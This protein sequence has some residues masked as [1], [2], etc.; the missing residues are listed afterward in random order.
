MNKKGIG[1]IIMTAIISGVSIYLNKSGVSFF[2]PVV[3]TFMKNVLAALILSLIVLSWK[4]ISAISRLNFRSWITLVIIGLI[5]GSLP[6]ILFFKG[7]AATSALQGSFIHKTMFIYVSAL[8]VIF[9]KEKINK[10]FFGGAI[11]VLIGNLIVIRGLSLAPNWG[12][13][14]ILSA[15]LLWALENIISKHA[16]KKIHCDTIAWARMFFGAIF[17]LAYL[18]IN[19]QSDLA[20]SLNLKQIG[21]VMLASVLLSGYVITWYR[22]LAKIPVSVASSVL[23]LGSPVTTMLVILSSGKINWGE[24]LS[25]FFIVSGV[26]VII[27]FGYAG[28]KKQEK[29]AVRT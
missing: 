8:A 11:L 18:W 4:N 7:L 12:D 17:I 9:L 16:M 29:E 3:F 6:F 26:I 23:I 22:G 28:I 27:I 25:A 14:L 19:G 1:L 15:T 10:Y 5:G 24:I 13:F 21:W 20:T 2:D